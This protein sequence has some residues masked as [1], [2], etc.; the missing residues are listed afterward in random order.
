M[1]HGERRKIIN[2]ISR[3]FLPLIKWKHNV[4]FFS[5]RFNKFYNKLPLNIKPLEVAIMVYYVG[6]FLNE[7]SYVEGEK[8]KYPIENARRCSS[9]RMKL[10]NW[11]KD[12]EIGTRP[13]K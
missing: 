5:K 12:Q 11:R 9:I 4:E 6:S 13:R 8:I 2:I 1:Q 3:N 7:F 10:D